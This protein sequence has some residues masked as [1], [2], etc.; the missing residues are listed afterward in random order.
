VLLL[1]S[2]HIVGMFLSKSYGCH[3]VFC[4]ASVGERRSSQ[5]RDSRGCVSVTA[6][7]GQWELRGYPKPPEPTC[8]W[9]IPSQV[10]SLL[11]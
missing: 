1:L 9:K 3:S 10:F 8:V 6:R 2:P 7:Q 5:Y 4:G 11:S